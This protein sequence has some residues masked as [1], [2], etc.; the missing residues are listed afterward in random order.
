[1]F[2]HIEEKQKNVKMEFICRT[3]LKVS[4]NILKNKRRMCIC[5][6]LKARGCIYKIVNR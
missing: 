5:I 6:S 2:M 4:T 3:F 1:M